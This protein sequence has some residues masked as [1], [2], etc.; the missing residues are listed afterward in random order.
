[1]SDLITILTTNN[2]EGID[3]SITKRAPTPASPVKPAA[4]AFWAETPKG[5]DGEMDGLHY[6]EAGSTT[7]LCGVLTKATPG[8]PNEYMARLCMTCTETKRENEED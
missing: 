2:L 5:G 1:M 7:A 3:M 4:K 8:N 6:R